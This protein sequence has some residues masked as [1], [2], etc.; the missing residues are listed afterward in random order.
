MVKK[1]LLLCCCLLAILSGCATTAETAVSEAVD[2]MAQEALLDDKVVLEDD[3]ESPLPSASSDPADWEID[4][5][6][7]FITEEMLPSD[8]GDY[9]TTEYQGST[10]STYEI[11]TGTEWTNQ[12]TVI[13]GA[14]EGPVIYVIAGVHGDE[15]A[16]WKAGD[17]LKK[18]SIQAGTLYILS[19]ANRWGATEEPPSRYVSGE[20]DLNRNFPGNPEGNDGQQLAATIFEDVQRVAP[21]FIFDLHE[22]QVINPG[23]DFLGSCLIFTSLDGMGDMFMEMVLE[24]EMG[25]LFSQPITY[26]SPGPVGSVNRVMTTELSTPTITVETFRGYPM[27]VRIGDQLD[28]VHYVLTYYGL[29]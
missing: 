15:Q 26:Y 29:L 3:I 17:L 27:E 18:I 4:P 25:N 22:A 13:E 9:F 16:A 1:H 19:P 11:G 14:Q 7:D 28:I 5:P 8:F 23:L 2:P 6:Y 21:D 12:V 10:T 24:S 20:Y